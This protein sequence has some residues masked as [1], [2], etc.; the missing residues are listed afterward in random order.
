MCGYGR[1]CAKHLQPHLTCAQSEVLTSGVGHILEQSWCLHP[2][3][4]SSQFQ[5]Q[6]MSVYGLTRYGL[7]MYRRLKTLILM[8]VQ[9]LTSSICLE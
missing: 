5:T 9:L 1:R 4:C 7:R 3:L 6:Q 2:I 8:E